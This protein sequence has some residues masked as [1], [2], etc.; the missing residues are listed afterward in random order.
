MTYAG[1]VV[2]LVSI[3]LKGLRCR[4][5]PIQTTTFGPHPERTVGSLMNR[6]N[7]IITQTGRVALY[8][9]KGLE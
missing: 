6:P 8:I 1:R 5:I 4:I 3:S 2:Y 7:A 9:T